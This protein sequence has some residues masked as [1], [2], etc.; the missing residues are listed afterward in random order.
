MDYE[1]GRIYNADE[2]RE[3]DGSVWLSHKLVVG[4]LKSTN[5]SISIPF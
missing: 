1:C 5:S 3:L 4:R 2:L